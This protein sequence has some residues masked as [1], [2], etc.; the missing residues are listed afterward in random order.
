MNIRLPLQI[1]NGQ[2]ITEEKMKE[3]I[4]RN[5]ETLLKTAHGTV[6]CDPEYGFELSALK[7]E[8]FNETEGTVFTTDRHPSSIYRKKISG[9]S[10]NLMTFAAEFNEVLKRY[11]QRLTDTNVVMSYIREERKI[12]LI[13]R[14]QVKDYEIPYQYKTAIIVWS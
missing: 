4:N 9:S 3:S 11:E 13:I 10:K 5:I 14:G 7:F 6:T 12:Q 2:L 8:N 1:S